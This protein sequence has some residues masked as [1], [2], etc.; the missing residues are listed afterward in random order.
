MPCQLLIGLYLNKG[1]ARKKEDVLA[2]LEAAGCK[3]EDIMKGI[4]LAQK[5][6]FFSFTKGRILALD[7]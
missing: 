1:A 4:Q 5:E 3:P 6:K 7:Y 2:C